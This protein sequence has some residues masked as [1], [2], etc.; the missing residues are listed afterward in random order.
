[1]FWD[2]QEFLELPHQGHCTQDLPGLLS[3]EDS[4]QLPDQEG[5]NESPEKENRL[6]SAYQRGDNQEQTL[7]H[8]SSRAVWPR[9]IGC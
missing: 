8:A 9:G 3:T 2:Q 4:A 6:N 5:S 1:M 7:A